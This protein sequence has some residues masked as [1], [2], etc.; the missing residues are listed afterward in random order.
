MECT[1]GALEDGWLS[2]D[3]GSSVDD[4]DTDDISLMEKGAI[5]VQRA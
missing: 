1:R 2:D 5:G 4:G 3:D